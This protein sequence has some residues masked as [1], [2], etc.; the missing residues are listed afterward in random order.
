MT[1]G[2]KAKSWWSFQTMLGQNLSEWCGDG[3]EEL[4]VEALQNPMFAQI[5]TERVC[6][7]FELYFPVLP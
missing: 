6:A 4:L 5:P 3:L 7:S 1:L 2:G